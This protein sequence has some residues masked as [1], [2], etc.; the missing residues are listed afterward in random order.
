MMRLYTI[1]F[2]QKCA[3]TFFELLRQHDVQQL[4]DIRL[5]PGG[6]PDIC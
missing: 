1:G 2:T 4:A 6:Q 3:E 5:N